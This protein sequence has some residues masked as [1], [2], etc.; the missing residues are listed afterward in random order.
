[1]KLAVAFESI[2]LSVQHLSWCRGHCPDLN[3]V[4]PLGDV[5]K[6]CSTDNALPL[7]WALSVTKWERVHCW[8]CIPAGTIPLFSRLQS[9]R[10]NWTPLPPS[11]VPPQSPPTPHTH[12]FSPSALNLPSKPPTHHPLLLPYMHP[13]VSCP[14]LGKDVL[15]A[16]WRGGR[17]GC[18]VDTREAGGE[19]VSTRSPFL[20]RT[21]LEFRP[22]S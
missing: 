19:T 15:S 5:L 11:K 10:L 17:G 12:P 7:V 22:L 9:G 21:C 8:C 6:N 20:I 4:T 16:R 2:R 3:P 14:Y 18:W 13:L 1:M